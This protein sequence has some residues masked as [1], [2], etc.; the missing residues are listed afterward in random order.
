[1]A[2]RKLGQVR[3]IGG[4]WRQ[5]R[6]PVLPIDGLRP[7]SDRTREQLFNWL[8]PMIDDTD[9]LDLFAGTGA[10]GL[11]A[12]SRGAKRAFL[13]EADPAAANNLAMQIQRLHAQTRVQLIHEEALCWLTHHCRWHFDIVFL[14][15]P[16][17][18]SIW[19]ALWPCLLPHLNSPSWLY[20]EWAATGREWIV[21]ESCE[22]Y[23]QGQSR[24]THYA[25]FR[26]TQP[27]SAAAPTPG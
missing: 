2:P 19:P 4:Q 26:Y 25:L 22:I 23:R 10:L 24:Q 12:V 15:P 11:E 5:T 1:M 14:D 9:V 3:I 13:V 7:S 8:N 18:H 27:R 6:L 21:P 16:F 17:A 20:A